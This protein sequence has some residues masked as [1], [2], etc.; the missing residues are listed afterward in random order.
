LLVQHEVEQASRGLSAIAELFV[1]NNKQ[2]NKSDSVSI[3]KGKRGKGRG[4]S[5][6]VIMGSN[7][8]VIKSIIYKIIIIL[9]RGI[10]SVNRVAVLS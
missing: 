9:V 3:Q 10:R 2:Y 8:G 7:L 6:L 4:L 1:K 5:L